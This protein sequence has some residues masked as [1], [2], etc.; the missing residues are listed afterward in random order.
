MKLLKLAFKNVKKSYKDYFIYFL[1]LMFS[2]CLFYTFNSFQAQEEIMALSESQ[3]AMLDTVALFMNALSVFVAFVLAFLILYANNFLIKRRKK[4]FGVYM[5]LG[6]PKREISRILVYETFLVGIMSLVAGLFLGILC[7]QAIGV[8]TA[9]M[10][11]AE[12]TYHLIF[13]ADSAIVTVLSFSVIFVIII[14]LNTRIIAKVKLI[15]LLQAKKKLEKQRLMKPWFAVLVFILSI[16]ML[17]TAYYFTSSS[18]EIFASMLLPILLIGSVGTIL[19]FVSL[20]GFLLQFIR[21]SKKM[22]FR[23]LNMFVLRQINAKINT[24][25]IS[26]SI[27]C[28]MLLLSIGALS[29]GLSLNNTLTTTVERMTPYS[30]SY[31]QKNELSKEEL[32]KALMLEQSTYYNQLSIYIE[33]GKQLEDMMDQLP[34]GSAKDSLYKAANIEYIRLSD[35]NKI[36]KSQN[37][38]TMQLNKTEAFFVTSNA[39]MLEYFNDTTS[40][41]VTLSVYGNHVSVNQQMKDLFI[42]SNTQN[43]M[44][45][46]VVADEV[47]PANATISNV[48]WNV[49]LKDGVDSEA[50]NKQ[51]K[52]N[53]ETYFK[54]Q[55]FSFFSSTKEE[56]EE[57]YYGL[58]MLFTYIGLYLGVVFLMASAA[59][60]ALQQ[61]SEAEDNKANYEILRKIGAPKKMMDHSIFGQIALY[62]SLPLL[63]ALVHACVGVPAVSGAFTFLFGLEDMW[64]SN[65]ITAGIIVLIYGSYFLVTYQ[66]YKTTLQ[67]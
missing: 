37:L 17:A 14:L 47:L 39:M 34:E 56:I 67:K 7:S 44:L 48:Y 52:E 15:D 16:G 3:S 12:V 57:A 28:L 42:P 19:F 29:T 10:F 23:K 64:K 24:N 33:D 30:Y 25:C 49:N 36:A 61:L 60:L 32:K 66:G 50:Y 35:Y 4:E 53:M 21:C 2:V 41:P 1:T 45:G 20:S 27:V 6:M 59:I 11:Q 54:G 38:A 51:V 55:D 18:L 13:S 5:L 9:Q 8:L 26:M 43:F 58:G 65:L 62:F 46:V 31:V 22:Y 40:T 63:L